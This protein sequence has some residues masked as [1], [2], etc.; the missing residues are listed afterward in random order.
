MCRQSFL[1]LFAIY[2]ILSPRETFTRNKESNFFLCRMSILYVLIHFSND[3][4]VHFIRVSLFR[5]QTNKLKKTTSDKV[6]LPVPF[7]ARIYFYSMRRLIESSYAFQ[8]YS[9]RLKRVYTLHCTVFLNHINTERYIF[10]EVCLRICIK[11][12]KC[13][14]HMWKR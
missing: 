2:R 10:V 5:R 9:K 3:L 7:F 11:Y 6:Q 13:K 14:L 8:K 4:G 1:S 12:A